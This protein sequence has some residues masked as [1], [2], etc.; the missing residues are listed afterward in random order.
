MGPNKSLSMSMCGREFQGHFFSVAQ[1]RFFRI[2]PQSIGKLTPFKK[3]VVFFCLS[4]L[5]LFCKYVTLDLHPPNPVAKTVSRNN[6]CWVVTEI[7]G[8]R[9]WMARTIPEANYI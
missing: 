6:P 3:D 9:G 4:S 1:M 7:L 8:S 2:F 5:R